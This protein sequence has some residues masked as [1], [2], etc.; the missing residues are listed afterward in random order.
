VTDPVAGAEQGGA[1]HAAAAEPSEESPESFP[2]LGELT[3]LLLTADTVKEVLRRVVVAAR[4]AIPGA[5]LVSITIRHDDGRLETPTVT[6][7]EAVELDQAQY[8]S[9]KGPCV[10]AAEPDGPAYAL[11][12][13]LAHD[14]AWPDFAASATAHGFAAV[15]STALLSSPEPVP[16]T[17]AMNLYSR[18]REGFDESARDL[19]FLLATH[20]S[21]A[22]VTAHTRQAL[23]EAENTVAHLRQA[24][25]G[26]TVI[27]QATGI[28]M[29]R[30]K[31]T[32]E[33][34][35]EVLSR[36]SQNRNIKVARL[37]ALLTDET[38]IADQL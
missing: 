18:N 25:E 6:G 31:L 34:A 8:R 1:R 10:D 38:A 9:G 17:G 36:T 19:A 11:S 29:A 23:A 4:H 13:D 33:Q 7:P 5:D 14:T 2:V 21:L 35:F 24:L 16:F 12:N 22:L 20:A 15:L 28:L 27:G 26:R 37:A 3:R 30:R 32:A